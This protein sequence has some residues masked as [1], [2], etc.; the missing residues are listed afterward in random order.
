[1]FYLSFNILLSLSVKSIASA[2]LIRSGIIKGSTQS[3][4]AVEKAIGSALC[5][6]TKV[7]KTVPKA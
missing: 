6:Y 2:I 5:I 3:V 1:M 4:S 7:K